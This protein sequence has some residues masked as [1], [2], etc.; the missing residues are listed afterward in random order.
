MSFDI[1]LK[2][3]QIQ[4]KPIGDLDIVYNTEKLEQDVIKIAITP[5]G[6]N[7]LHSWYGSILS[8]TLIGAPFD[9]ELA[10][11]LSVDQLISSLE[12]LRILQI[13]QSQQQN[14]SASEAIANILDVVFERDEKEFRKLSVFIKI[15]SRSG[16][17]SIIELTGT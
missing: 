4:L 7:K 13:Q 11:N 12:N 9:L 14:V 8:Q 5:L 10:K 3:G 16:K 15:L 1:K 2:D 6:A 17:N